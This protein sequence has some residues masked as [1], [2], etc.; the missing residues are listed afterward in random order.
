M[1][2]FFLRGTVFLVS[3]KKRE[4]GKNRWQI[5]SMHDLSMTNLS[6]PIWVCVSA[7]YTY[8]TKRACLNACFLGLWGK[9]EEYRKPIHTLQSVLKVVRTTTIISPRDRVSGSLNVKKEK[10]AKFWKTQ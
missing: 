9:G 5:E 7:L 8:K 4:I 3:F 6:K 2:L 10:R 1:C